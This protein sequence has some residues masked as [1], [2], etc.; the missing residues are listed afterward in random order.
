MAAI[1]D[2]KSIT[3]VFKV[4]RSQCRKSEVNRIYKAGDR[5]S[6]VVCVMK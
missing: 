5:T 6:G 2:F 4:G 3:T 1:R